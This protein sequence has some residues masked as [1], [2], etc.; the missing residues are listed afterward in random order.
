MVNLKQNLYGLMKTKF[1]ALILLLC[2]GQVLASDHPVSMWLIEGNDNRVYLLGSIHLL[3]RQDHPLPQVIENAYED[4]EALLMELD[5][6][7]L[8]PVAIQSSTNRLGVLNDGRTLRDLMGDKLYS[9]AEKQADALDIPF[10]LLS[11]SEPWFAAIT[12][13]QMALLRIGF[14]PLYGIEMHMSLKAS[15]DQKPIDGLETI[16]EQ[17]KFLDDLSLDAQKKLLMQTLAESRTLQTVMDDIIR[18]WRIGD[19]KYIEE[20]MLKDM[21][22][23]SE[24]Y[25]TLVVNRNNRWIKVIETLL[26]DTNDYLVVVG[27]LHLV[28]DDGLPALLEKRGIA[29]AQMREISTQ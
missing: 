22:Q 13:E 3:R 9:E 16:E 2:N 28:G 27:A 10:E 24:L 23:Y 15:Q 21:A 6:D 18:A 14:N 20:T 8:D 11:K 17:L 29:T 26:D 5:M 19:I 1:V 25:R 7:D 12:I 4:A